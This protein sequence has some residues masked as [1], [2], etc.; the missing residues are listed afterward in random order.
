MWKTRVCSMKN[1][2]QGSQ[3]RQIFASTGHQNRAFRAEN[4]SGRMILSFRFPTGASKE[5]PVWKT[6]EFSM[7]NARPGT[8]MRPGPAVFRFKW[9][10]ESSV[11]G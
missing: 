11:S 4:G 1:G 8:S 9:G 6:R 5:A 3:V 7:K 2:I 10:S